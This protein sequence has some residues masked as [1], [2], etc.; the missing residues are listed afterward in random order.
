MRKKELF[1]AI[2]LV[3]LASC[4]T[5]TEDKSTKGDIPSIDAKD[6]KFDENLA[7]SFIEKQVSFGPRVPSTES[8]DA[9]AKWILTELRGLA[10]TAFIQEFD[11]VTYDGKKHRGKNILA[12]LNPSNPNR[13]QLAAHWDTRPV[14]D[15][16][17]LN[18]NS[19]ILGADDAG[20]G[21]G[22]ILSLLKTLKAKKI[23]IGVDIIFFDIEDYGQPQNSGLLPMEHSWCL[24]SQYWGKNYKETNR[25]R[26]GILLDMVGSK[27]ASFSKEEISMLYASNLVNRIW[28]IAANL[29]YE[30]TFKEST[31]GTIEDDHMYMNTLAA[32]PTVD[33]IN[34]RTEQNRFG[35]HWHTHRDNLEVIDKK[36]LKVV[37]NVLE[38]LIIEEDRII[39]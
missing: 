26:W 28:N 29:G 30:S 23:T 1:F 7:Y 31:M 9:C 24:G 10:D 5:N 25:P 35:E 12:K 3:L 34:Y 17:V 27:G 4:K 13:I 14:A 32:I 20:S 11:A 33:I 18:Q 39:Q 22:V 15:Q 36:T 16:D 19:P 2:A 8:H 6:L 37:G 21:V 38:Q